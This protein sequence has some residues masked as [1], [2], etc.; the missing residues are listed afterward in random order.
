MGI[1]ILIT[2]LLIGWVQV[3]LVNFIWICLKK[4][5]DRKEVISERNMNLRGIV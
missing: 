5:S 2:H 3:L 1:G 4:S